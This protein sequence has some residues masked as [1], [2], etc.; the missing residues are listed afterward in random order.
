[1]TQFEVLM[2]LKKNKGISFSAKEISNKLSITN[3][4]VVTGLR[5]LY[6]SGFL[7]RTKSIRYVNKEEKI[8]NIYEYKKF[9]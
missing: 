9:F 6:K 7:L 4:I 1:M 5:K 2:F 8:V 3:N